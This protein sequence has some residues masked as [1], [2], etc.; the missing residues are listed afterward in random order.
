MSVPLRKLDA[1]SVNANKLTNEL[2]YGQYAYYGGNT[3]PN[4]SL[5]NGYGDPSGTAAALNRAFFPGTFPVHASYSALGAGQTLLGPLL[6]TTGKGLDISQDQT[7]DEGV[8]YTFGANNTLGP[9]TYTVGTHNAFIRLKFRIADVSGTDDCCVGFRKMEAI[10]ANVDDYDEAAFLNV[11]LGDIKIETILN[12]AATT[13]TDTTQNW[14]DDETHTLEVQLRGRRVVF[15]I[16]GAA[17]T[18]SPAT[19]FDFDASEVVVPFFYFLQATT[20]P[21]KVWW[22]ELEIGQLKSKSANGVNF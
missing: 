12:N 14:A 17:P 11:I 5:A 13:T 3:Q 10:Q 22:T 4:L 9:F 1:Q 20:S 2:R 15:L 7:D 6:D 8:Q 16:D 19:A 21:G 18:V